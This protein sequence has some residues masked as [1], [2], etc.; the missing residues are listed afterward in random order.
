[1]VRPEPP[2]TNPIVAATPSDSA[3]TRGEIDPICMAT[4]CPG[5]TVVHIAFEAPLRSVGPDVEIAATTP[6]ER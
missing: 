5:M 1:V 6:T 2:A 3:T 4:V